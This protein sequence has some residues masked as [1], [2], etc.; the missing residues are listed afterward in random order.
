MLKY[1]IL[2]D[3]HAGALTSLLTDLPGRDPAVESPVTRAFAAALGDFLERGGQHGAEAPDLVLLGDVLDLQFSDRAAA[4]TSARTFLSALANTGGLSKHVIAT[5]GNHDHALWTDARL[6]LEA[7]AFSTKPHAPDYRA[8]TPAFS[9]DPGA[10]SRL[11][12]AVLGASG[13]ETVDLRYPNLGFNG[14]DRTVFL[15]H[16]HFVESEYR[17]VSALKDALQGVPRSTISAEDLAA[18]N[19]GWIDFA[20]SS[21]GDAAGLGGDAERL[22]QNMLTTTGFRRLSGHWAEKLADALAGL[23]PGGRRPQVREVLGMLSQVGLDVTLGKFRDTE[24]YAEVDALTSGGREGLE[25][26]LSG[27]SRGQ[28]Q[29]ELGGLPGDLAFVFGHTHK[30]FEARLAVPGFAAPLGVYNTG[31]WTLN[32]PRLD[33]AEGASMVLI[34][35]GF[36]TAAVRLFNT[37]R[38]GSV[39]RAHVRMLSNGTPGEDRFR[40]FIEDCLGPEKPGDPWSELAR[41]AAEDIS[42]RR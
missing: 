34:D 42:L 17:L 22:Y 11:L 36:N 25:W 6:A 33:N 4:A 30:P 5:A 37:P 1:V 27:A 19:A 16:G 2:S 3:L 23:L 20:W 41:T 31:G 21:F 35:E 14:E 7:H 24:R 26:Y 12:E 10:R 32:G 15:H 29:A 18:E 28:I 9:P 38:N 39:E 13:F 8:A 40:A